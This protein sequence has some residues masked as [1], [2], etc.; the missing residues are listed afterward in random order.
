MDDDELPQAEGCVPV[1]LM[2]HQ[3]VF[4]YFHSAVIAAPPPLA[5]GL[6]TCIGLAQSRAGEC[7]QDLYGLQASLNLVWSSPSLFTPPLLISW[8]SPSISPL[9]SHPLAQICSGSCL[10]R[11]I[12]P[13]PAVAPQRP[14][15]ARLRHL[16]QL[17]RRTLP[18]CVF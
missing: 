18:V 1:R 15:R 12:Y 14:P 6:I 13:R 8:D 5:R 17:G 4:N 7:D 11:N 9:V 16:R 3:T 2:S 10:N